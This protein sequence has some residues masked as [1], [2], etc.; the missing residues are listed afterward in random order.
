MTKSPKTGR[1]LKEQR[2]QNGPSIFARFV[3]S[4]S[5]DDDQSNE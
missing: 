3:R 2:V 1:E 4:L 5:G